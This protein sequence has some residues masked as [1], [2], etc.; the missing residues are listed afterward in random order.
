MSSNTYIVV[1]N[2]PTLIKQTIDSLIQKHSFTDATV[3][4]YDWEETNLATVLEDVDTISFLTP[5]KVVILQYCHF[6]ESTASEDESS[7]K[8]L[9]NYIHHS[10]ED[11]LFILTAT[12][13]DERKKI[14]KNL[15]KSISVI[16]MIPEINQFIKNQFQSYQLEQGVIS[17][18]KEYVGDNF[19]RMIHEC[20]KLKLFQIDSKKISCADVKMLIEKPLED[21]DEISF[22][23]VRS[24][25]ERNK[26]ESFRLYH[27]M[28]KL[29]LECYAII[30]L[31][32]SQYRLLYQVILLNKKHMS[33]EKIAQTL[34]IHPFR[35]SKTLELIHQYQ[36]KDVSSFLKQLA[37]IDFKIKSGLIDSTFVLELLILN[38]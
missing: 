3:T 20:E 31:L 19:E 10:S 13:L 32:E 36:L 33:K 27:E 38:N 18:L 21:K 8:H 35:I 2:S 34:N 23:F 7:L 26:K 28:Q 11:V 37:E 1:G 6:L 14:V 17:L 9:E 25:A 24:I 22:A 16:E 5:K 4:T 15:R 30:G 12:K 29:N